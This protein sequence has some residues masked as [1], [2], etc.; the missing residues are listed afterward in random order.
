M[1]MSDAAVA[2]RG[3]DL[4]AD[5]AGAED[6]GAAVGELAE[7]ALGEFDAC[8]GDRHRARTQF[9]FGAN[10]FAGFERA[11]EETVENGAG[12]AVLMGKTIGFADLAKDFGFT[13]EEGVEPG[14]HAEEMANG[15]A[16]V[17]LVEDAIENVGANGME[18]TEEGRE[19]G[20]AFVGSFGRNTVNLA[21]V[22][23]GE[24]ERFFE[25]AARAELVGGAAGL[26]GGE[27][28]TLA[29]LE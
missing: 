10:T 2:E 17:V 19:A 13:E 28:D 24:D 9:R 8:G 21:A 1:K 20:S 27:G 25:E 26:F 3:N 18:F 12:G 7:D 15:G 22:A 5:R 14:G 23:G 16:I 11:L 29:E 4:L 6:Q